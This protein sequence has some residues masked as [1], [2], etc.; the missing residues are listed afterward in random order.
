MAVV[1]ISAG[2]GLT[3]TAVYIAVAAL[4][5][6]ALIEIGIRLMTAPMFAFCLGVV[7]TIT[8]PLASVSFAAVAIARSPLMVT[9]S[10]QP[11]PVLQAIRSLSLVSAIPVLSLKARCG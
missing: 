1:V 6:P 8:P 2:M 9:G 10:S 11:G 4:I 3:R 5:V 7:S